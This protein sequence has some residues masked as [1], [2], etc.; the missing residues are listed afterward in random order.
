MPSQHFSVRGTLLDAAPVLAPGQTSS[1]TI[2]YQAYASTNGKVHRSGAEGSGVLVVVAMAVSEMMKAGALRETQC[3]HV[4]LRALLSEAVSRQCQQGPP[5]TRQHRVLNA[6]SPLSTSRQRV[7][8]HSTRCEDP[9]EAEEAGEGLRVHGRFAC[10]ADDMGETP[11][12]R[13]GG[14][15]FFSQG[16]ASR[17]TLPPVRMM[18]TRR[19]TTGI[20]PSRMAA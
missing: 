10:E 8:E 13:K 5:S 1:L 12:P 17:S 11:L 4:P 3:E 9:E 15:Y 6:R 14:D 16:S 19:P 18:P 2:S 7:P 20:L